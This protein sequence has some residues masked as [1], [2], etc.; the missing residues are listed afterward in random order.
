VTSDWKK[1]LN[2]LRWDRRGNVFSAESVPNHKWIKLGAQSPSALVLEDRI[3]V[4]FCSRSLPDNDGQFVSRPFFA[5]FRRSDPSELISVSPEPIAPLGGLG[6]F[7]EFGINPICVV[8]NETE[9]RIYYGGWTRCESVRF[10]AAIGVLVSVD[11]G[12]T[13]NRLAPG[14]VISFSPDE[15][16]LMGSPHVRIINGIWYMW[17]VAGKRWFAG[18]ERLEPIY[19]LR[20]ATSEDGYNWKKEGRDIIEDVLGSSE[21]QASGEVFFHEDE[22][23]MIFSYRGAIDYKSGDQQYRMG[24]AVSKNLTEWSRDDSYHEFE[25]SGTGWDS[26]S[27]SYPTVFNVDAETYMYY[28]GNGIGSTGF[29]LAKLTS[30]A[31]GL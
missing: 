26:K 4:Y 1:I 5:D 20:M 21:C 17:Y 16:F 31:G 25:P 13:F 3:R 18:S 19:K 6:Q 28:Q 7:D 27:V 15:P 14:P 8:R 10:N 30:S 11:S 2:S 23:H 24:H 12:N 29:G 9:V 22:Y